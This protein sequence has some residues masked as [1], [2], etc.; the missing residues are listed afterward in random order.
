MQ[1]QLTKENERLIEQYANAMKQ[2]IATYTAS[3]TSIVNVF[4]AEMILQKIKKLER[5]GF[6]PKAP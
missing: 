5:S 2:S 3:P 1:I 4:F 6:V